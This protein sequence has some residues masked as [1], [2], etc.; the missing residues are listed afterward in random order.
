MSSQHPLG[1]GNPDNGEEI[2]R[3]P[4]S[5]DPSGIHGAAPIEIHGIGIQIKPGLKLGMD[6]WDGN[7]C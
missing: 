1:I 2:P 6:P 4:G 7:P 5:T 3:K